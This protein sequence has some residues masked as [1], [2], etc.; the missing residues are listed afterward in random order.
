MKKVKSKPNTP[1]MNIEP[2]QC[3]FGSDVPF[4]GLVILRFHV[5]FKGC[6]T[7]HTNH[8]SGLL[9]I[10]QPMWEVVNWSHATP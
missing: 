7:N 5:N 6:S 1:W 2:Q 4:Q 9:A 8:N 3:R 10:K